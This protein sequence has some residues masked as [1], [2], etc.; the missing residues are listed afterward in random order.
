[1]VVENKTISIPEEY[2]LN[3]SKALDVNASDVRFNTFMP[4]ALK[5]RNTPFELYIYDAR[6]GRVI[7]K[8]SDASNGWN[9]V[10]SNTGEMLKNG[11]TVLWKVILK[12]PNPGEQREYSG[13]LVLKTE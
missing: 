5:E 2:N 11:S 7:F 10:D 6:S 9:G 4:Y 8:T 13:N 12:N 3:A 1:M